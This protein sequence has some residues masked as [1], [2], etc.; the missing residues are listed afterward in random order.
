MPPESRSL[1]FA[2]TDGVSLHALAWLD[3]D[4]RRIPALPPRILLHGGGA[5]AHWWDHLAQR[6][7]RLG[8]LYA[9]D[10][11]GHGDS[12]HPVER[13][14]GAFNTDLES[15]L[16]WLGREDVHLIGHSLGAA[17]AFDHASRHP[18]TRSV[19]L[20]DL[21]RGST[22]GSGRRARLALSLRR[23]YRSFDEAA[24][25]FRFLPES[26]HASEALRASIAAHSVREEP[27]GRFGYKF[28][29]GWFGLPSRPR[30]DP[31]DVR[32]PTLLIRGGES[33]LL[34]AEAARELARAL[35]KGRLAE[36]P[37][38]GHHVFIDRPQ[39]VLSL[40]EAFAGEAEPPEHREAPG[41]RESA[42]SAEDPKDDS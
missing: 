30:P 27:D 38:A 29:P 41:G 25:R 32:C 8:P 7:S 39:E 3:P 18:E 5:N 15:L 28:D 36:V 40:I 2:T 23:T 11:R 10:F 21:A 42:G 33:H 12:E 19:T 34:S 16:D 6:L 17:V 31:A 20:I 35:P 9:L 4:S 26:S 37:E 1:R 14:V 13:M 22:K 24:L